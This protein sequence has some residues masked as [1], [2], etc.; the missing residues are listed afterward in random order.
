[1]SPPPRPDD[2]NGMWYETERR[3]R[4]EIFSSPPL[5][6]SGTQN[7]NRLRGHKNGKQSYLMKKLQSL[8]PSGEMTV[9][10]KRESCT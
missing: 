4:G 8:M 10:K 9:K 5:P 1:M 2:P 3:R 6:C 7:S